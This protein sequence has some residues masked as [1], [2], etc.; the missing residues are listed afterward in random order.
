MSTP[1]PRAARS[2]SPIRTRETSSAPVRPRTLPAPRSPPEAWWTA[3]QEAIAA[4]GGLDDVA[5]LSISGQ[6]HGLVALD[7]EGR[8]IRDAL[9]WNDLRSKAAARD[10]INAVGAA[11]YVA[12]TGVLPVA[13]FTAAKLL[14]LRDAEPGNAARVAAVALPHDWLS[15]RFLGYGPADASV[16]GPVLEALVTDASD[17]SGTA[18]FDPSTSRYDLDLFR[19]AFGASARE[20]AG[21]PCAADTDAEADSPDVDGDGRAASAIVLPRVLA[22]NEAAGHSPDG[23]LVGPGAGDN[24]AA[25]LGLGVTSG[26]LVISIGTS[27]TVFGTTDLPIADSSGTV[28]GF[29][30]ADGGRLPLVATLNA[31]RV[32]DS[33]AKLLRVSHDELAALALASQPGADGLTLVPYFEG[34]RTPNLPNATARLEGMTLANSAAENV[35][36][37]FVEGMLCGLADGLDAVQA[38]G[39]E[40]GRL[41]LIGGAARNPAVREVARDIFTVPID[42]PEQAEYV[43]IGAARQAAW[44]L[45]GSLPDWTVELVAT[46]HPRP[47]RVRQQYR[48]C[49]A[50]TAAQQKASLVSPDRTTP[51]PTSSEL[52]SSQ[53][54]SSEL[55]SSQRSSSDQSLTDHRG[56]SGAHASVKG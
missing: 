7:A 8:V 52:S 1:R 54:S 41:V 31:A 51:E 33:A 20:A 34:E 30:S 36:R 17:A 27:G 15:W 29:A 3:L 14:W 46:L 26:D 22:P 35:A 24:A 55:S 16:R 39:L 44:T 21:L 2:S 32:L 19:I 12:R 48:S 6:Q 49:A 25:A 37:A 53:R 45:S 5:G 42:V 28:A 40:A 23:I 18:Y 56:S 38:Q 43:A 10:L 11:D 47:S 9:L 50:Q 4:A 13:S